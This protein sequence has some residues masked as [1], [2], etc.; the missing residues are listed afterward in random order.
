MKKILLSTSVIIIAAVAA[1]GVTTALFND[2][3]TSSGNIF[4]AGSIDLTV[5]SYGETYN[6]EDLSE[7]NWTARDL[8]EDHQF[9]TFDDVKPGDYGTRGISL[10]VSDNPA[11]ACLLLNNE[12]D[13]ENV[14]LDPELDAGDTTD[15]GVP[16]GELSQNLEVF[17]WRDLNQN[18]SYNPNTGETP[19]ITDG[20][21]A[22]DSF[23]DI[24]YMV[25]FDSETD[26]SIIGGSPLM[27]N[28]VRHIQIAWCAGDQTVDHVTGAISCDG[29]IMGDKSQSDSYGADVILYAEQVRNNPNFTCKDV[30]LPT[31]TPTPSLTVTPT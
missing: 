17:T 14:A 29:S 10:H 7:S 16:Y 4:I 20:N 18:G 19:L 21:F 25:I 12:Q 30:F 6:G 9:F 13:D 5:D 2:T 11:Y 31:P 15:D 23:F 22:I 26:T 3:E 28:D 1:I 27:L 8:T 24:T